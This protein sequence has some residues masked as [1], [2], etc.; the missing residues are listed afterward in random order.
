MNK[1]EEQPKQRRLYSIHETAQ[2]LGGLGRTTIYELAKRGDIQ[3]VKIG[4]RSFVTDES[5]NQYVERLT[6]KTA[7]TDIA[8]SGDDA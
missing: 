2:Q 1:T 8:Q 5:L 7:T 6:P 3:L 4:A